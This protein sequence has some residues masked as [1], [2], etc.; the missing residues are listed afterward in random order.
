MSEQELSDVFARA[1]GSSVPDLGLLVA[2]ATAE[3]R[4]IRLRRRLAFTGAVAAVAALAVGGGLLLRPA[5]APPAVSAAAPGTGPGTGPAAS[6]SV[7]A[8]PVT[9]DRL[10]PFLPHELA[11]TAWEDTGAAPDG[12]TGLSVLARFHWASG[13]D[14]GT[15]EVRVQLADEGAQ[16]LIWG[17]DCREDPAVRACAPVGSGDVSGVNLT[18][19]DDQ[20]RTV[21]RADLMD[22]HGVRLVLSATGPTGDAPPLEP[23]AMGKIAVGLQQTLSADLDAYAARERARRQAVTAVTSPPASPGPALTAVPS[24]AP[25]SSRPGSAR[26]GSARPGSGEPTAA[27][28]GGP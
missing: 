21:N 18:L 3:G 17:H 6:P 19:S 26:P 4:S 15:I 16:T 25:G 27:G 28:G 13:G 11:L 12:S 10:L 22:P 7:P 24:G 5:A 9:L 20:G 23:S 14:A 1:V 8:R 2:G